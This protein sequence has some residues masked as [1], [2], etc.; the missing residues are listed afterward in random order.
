MAA[1][2]PCVVS[3][4]GPAVVWFFAGANLVAAFFKLS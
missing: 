1:K 3:Q 2:T 4:I